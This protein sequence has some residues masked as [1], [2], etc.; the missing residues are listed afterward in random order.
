[1]TFIYGLIGLKHVSL[2][3]TSCKMLLVSNIFIL[4]KLWRKTDNSVTHKISGLV[5]NSKYSGELDN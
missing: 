5:V 3:T 1:M 4:Y 2:K